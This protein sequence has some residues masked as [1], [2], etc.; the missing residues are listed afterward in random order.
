M[1]ANDYLKNL[2]SPMEDR[3]S[4]QETPATAGGGATLTDEARR[5]AEEREVYILGEGPRLQPIAYY[6]NSL[7]LRLHTG[8]LG[9]KAR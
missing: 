4:Q 5:Q 7:R 3:V 6:Q 8:N 9:L 1:P 2:E